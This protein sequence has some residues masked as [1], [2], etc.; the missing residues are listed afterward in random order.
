MKIRNSMGTQLSGTIGKDTVA[1]EGKTTS[2]IR[3]YA[4]PTNRNSPR[5]QEQRGR[6]RQSVAAWRGMSSVQQAFY[7]HLDSP[8]AGYHVFMSRAINS[9]VEGKGIETPLELA[10]TTPDGTR[11]EDASLIVRR[12]AV[13]LF[14]VPLAGT[15]KIALTVSD[16]PFEIAIRRRFEEDFV[17]A[18]DRQDVSAPAPF[19]HSVRLGILLVPEIPERKDSARRTTIRAVL[20]GLADPA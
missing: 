9:L 17:L 20:S 8:R 10:W 15:I 14:D 7:R 3:K 13:K 18:V 2:Y 11:I 19:L 5:Q 12:H 4:K 16:A 6:H 1:V